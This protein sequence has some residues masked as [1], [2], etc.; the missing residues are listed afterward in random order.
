M[1]IKLFMHKLGTYVFCPIVSFVVNIL[2]WIWNIRELR[3]A[4]KEKDKLK[5]IKSFTEFN[6]II[7]A[8]TWTKDVPVD[9]VPW[10]VTYIHRQYHDDCDGAAI[11][12]QW[13]LKQLKTKSRVYHLVTSTGI[14]GH[15]V[16]ITKDKSLM[17]SN[18]RVVSIPDGCEWKAFVLRWHGYRYK[19]I[20]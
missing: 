16:T 7:S 11:F 4:L 10:V 18:N 9:W 2:Y 15:A 12:S 3:S 6:E 14:S 5:N 19:Y 8:F 13:L 1:R 20:Y 17:V